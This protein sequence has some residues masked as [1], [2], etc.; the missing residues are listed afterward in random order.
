MQNQMAQTH[1]IADIIKVMNGGIEFYQEAKSTLDSSKYLTFFNR[2]IDAKEEAITELQKFAVDEQG[3]LEK[4][5]DYSVKVRQAYTNLLSMI[6][7]NS[8]TFIY[9]DQLEE[10]EDKVLGELDTALEV[11]Q[12]SDCEATL[13]HVK[14][15]M[16]ECHDEM[17][18]LQK[19]AAQH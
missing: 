19:N 3:K 17:K 15:K 4:G 12:P 18:A 10:L 8:A 14:V 2:M 13:K 16:Q 1:H 9:M 6:S 5:T 11:P 7:S